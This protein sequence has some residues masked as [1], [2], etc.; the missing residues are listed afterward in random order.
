MSHCRLDKISIE[1]LLLRC[2]IGI[3]DEERKNK[4]DVLINI[5]LYADLK[6]ASQSDRMEDTVDYKEIKQK[7][8]AMVEN[9]NFFLIERLAGKIAEICL[10]NTRVEKVK[11]RVNKPGA[12]RFAKSVAVEIVRD[13]QSNK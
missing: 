4:Q 10:E 13:K 9:S 7:I 6:T 2:I 8:I 12:L 1:D 5:T 11:V 3:Y